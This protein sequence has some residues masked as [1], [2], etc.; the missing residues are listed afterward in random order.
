LAFLLWR[1]ARRV[2][3]TMPGENDHSNI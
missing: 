2:I 1:Y 3:A